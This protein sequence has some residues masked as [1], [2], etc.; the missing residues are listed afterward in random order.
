MLGS[1]SHFPAEG[2][3]KIADNIW[4][5][6]QGNEVIPLTHN[7][8]VLKLYKHHNNAMQEFSQVT[9]VEVSALPANRFA[10]NKKTYGI[11]SAASNG[12]N[13]E[14]YGKKWFNANF[15][16]RSDFPFICTMADIPKA[17]IG[18]DV[19]GKFGPLVDIKRK[20]LL[21]PFTISTNASLFSFNSRKTW[22]TPTIY[23]VVEVIN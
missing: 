7:S 23:G 4:E 8:N 19:F 1:S 14:T 9:A 12:P 21:N 2:L 18:A 20:Q 13:I 5:V 11:I 17:I 16:L 6:L 22:I 15:C 3:T 10:Y